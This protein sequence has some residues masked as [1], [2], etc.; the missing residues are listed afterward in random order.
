MKNKSKQHQIFS[1]NG[2][3]EKEAAHTYDENKGTKTRQSWD[4]ARSVHLLN[5][6]SLLIEKASQIVLKIRIF[7][8]YKKYI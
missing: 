1:A 6:D 5:L 7:A 4:E 8:A 3:T 2:K